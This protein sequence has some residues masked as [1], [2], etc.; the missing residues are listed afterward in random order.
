MHIKKTIEDTACVFIVGTSNSTDQFGAIELASW[1]VWVQFQT[2]E[3]VDEFLQWLGF[4]FT[5]DPLSKWKFHN[6]QSGH[7]G[8]I[9]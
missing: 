2:R 9:K 1:R 4:L 5:W 6:L 3:N 7:V 8:D